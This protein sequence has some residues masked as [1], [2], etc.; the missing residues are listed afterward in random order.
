MEV[1]KKIVQAAVVCNGL[2]EF[3]NESCHKVTL[4]LGSLYY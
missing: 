4:Q 1:L 2:F 3:V